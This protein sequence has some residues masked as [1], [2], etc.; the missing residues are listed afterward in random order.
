MGKT[1]ADRR[2][3]A[4]ETAGQAGALPDVSFLRAA[5]LAT[6]RSRPCAASERGAGVSRQAPR[7]NAVEE[8]VETA[9]INS[10]VSRIIIPASGIAVRSDPAHAGCCF[11]DGLPGQ[12]NFFHWS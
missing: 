2:H 6:A 5:A 4:G 8:G 12:L 10:R 7:W 9:P 1:F 11:S 3:R